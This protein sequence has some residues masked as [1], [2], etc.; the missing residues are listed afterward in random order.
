MF[1]DFSLRLQ[2]RADPGLAKDLVET[3]LPRPGPRTIDA[4]RFSF[5]A[6]SVEPFAIFCFLQSNAATCFFQ[7]TVT[8]AKE[9]LQRHT[10]NH[11]GFLSKLSDI[12][13]TQY[14]GSGVWGSAL[15]VHFFLFVLLTSTPPTHQHQRP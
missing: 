8:M 11:A 4:V 6:F 5:P 10:P 9:A 3:V 2:C 1:S 12:H 14:V 7:L 13:A 15:F